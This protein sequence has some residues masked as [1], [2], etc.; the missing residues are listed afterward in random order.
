MNTG[1]IRVKVKHIVVSIGVLSLL[2]LFLHQVLIPEFKIARALNQLDSTAENQVGKV[3]A[4]LSK[5][6]NT[7]KRLTIIED[8]IISGMHD[9]ENYFYPIYF[10]SS[11]SVNTNGSAHS[12]FSF[13]EALPYLEEYMTNGTLNGYYLR[14]AKQ[15]AH[16][17]IRSGEYRKAEKFILDTEKHL[18]ASKKQDHYMV[19]D[20]LLLRVHL[21]NSANHNEAAIERLLQ[22]REKVNLQGVAFE[23]WV[24]LYASSLI[25]QGHPE[26]ALSIVEE[27]I[28]DALREYEEHQARFKDQK[29]QDSHPIRA[30][31]PLESLKKEVEH[32]IAAKHG[33]AA[34]I[35]GTVRRSDGTPLSNVGV[36]LR[37]ETNYNYSVVPSDI[38]VVTA[39]DGSFLFGGMPPGDYQIV[40]GLTYEQIDGWVWPDNNNQ[41]WI[42]IKSNTS[43]SVSYDIVMQPLM[44]L[45]SP[46]NYE[47]IDDSAIQ[48]EW[49]AFEG[50]VYYEVSIGLS[51][52]GGSSSRP[53]R[54][55]VKSTSTKIPLSE[56]YSYYFL[57]RTSNGVEQEMIVNNEALFSFSNPE[58]TYIWSVSAY[59]SNGHKL[60]QSN[61]YRLSEDTSSIIPMFQ[62]NTRSLTLAD[63]MLLSGRHPEA[64]AL[65]EK[66]YERD[67]QDVHA[68]RMIIRLHRSNGAHGS[69]SGLHIEK[70]LYEYIRPLAEFELASEE[71]LDLAMYYEKKRMW[72]EYNEWYGRSLSFL[73]SS[74][75]ISNQYSQSKHAIALMYQGEEDRALEMLEAIIPTD[76]SN[77][78]VG[79]WIALTLHKDGI[80]D[81]ALLI[82]ANYKQ[83]GTRTTDWEQ[84]LLYMKQAENKDNSLVELRKEGLSLYVSGQ[85]EKL[86]TYSQSLIGEHHEFFKALTLIR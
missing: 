29:F 58:G 86:E 53:I 61:G 10:S 36:Y 37:D 80:Y 42:E 50:A 15:L 48:F 77:R 34:E 66:A 56:L 12:K 26:K 68:L 52:E 82:S 73:E 69:G 11:G 67:P 35:R 40:L 85:I 51:Y 23:E 18:L 32:A 39:T 76:P 4:L 74:G 16:S 72:Q 21:Y 59:D 3:I 6:D 70:D 20:F 64:L 63:E 8:Y 27:A 78:F 79:S 71:I 19:N 5:T 83:K 84:L 55:N 24:R 31:N 49:E 60:S 33:Q 22:I 25:K 75:Q 30:D 57:I 41:D 13:E 54:S 46:I 38:H 45:V 47:I 14:A 81:Q 44:K 62:L 28:V 65:Y 7:S 1:T 43:E 17:Y 2:L 9:L